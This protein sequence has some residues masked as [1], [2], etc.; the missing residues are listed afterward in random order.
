MT[1]SNQTKNQSSRR[2]P[3][4]PACNLFPLFQD[5]KIPPK[6]NLLKSKR[7]NIKR[8]KDTG[9]NVKKARRTLFGESVLERLE[10]VEESSS[11]GSEISRFSGGRTAVV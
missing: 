7:I 11:T 9:R 8:T 3:E 1:K 4:W 2:P 6:S 5:E 10:V